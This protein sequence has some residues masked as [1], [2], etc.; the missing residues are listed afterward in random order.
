MTRYF[1]FL[2]ILFALSSGAIAQT[3]TA[4]TTRAYGHYREAVSLMRTNK[5][6]ALLL[7]RQAEPLFQKSKLY[8]A[9][10]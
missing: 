3:F 2:L 4:D 8:F 10:Q 9:L 5:D 1:L 7:F 6:S